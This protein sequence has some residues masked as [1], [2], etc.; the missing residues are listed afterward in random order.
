VALTG[1]VRLSLG[2][3]V[4]FIEEVDEFLMPMA[5]VDEKS[6]MR[7]RAGPSTSC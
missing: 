3:A 6:Q 2:N 7:I 1:A 4:D 5:S